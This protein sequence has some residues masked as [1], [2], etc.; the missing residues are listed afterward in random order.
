MVKHCRIDKTFQLTQSRVTLTAE[1]KARTGSSDGT[2]TRALRLVGHEAKDFGAGVGTGD[3]EVSD[4]E[5][6]DGETCGPEVRERE[7]DDGRRLCLCLKI[8]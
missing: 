7:N 8:Q 6:S 5:V 4:F 2:G 1:V 3:F